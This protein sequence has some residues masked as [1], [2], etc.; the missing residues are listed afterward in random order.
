VV[1]AIGIALCTWLTVGGLAPLTWLRFAIWFLVGVAIYALYG[2]R[3]S[4]LRKA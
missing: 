1:P 2:Y 3:K 4:A